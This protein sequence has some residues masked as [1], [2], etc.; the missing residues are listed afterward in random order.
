MPTKWSYE[1]LMVRQFKDNAYEKYFYDLEKE[2]SNSNFKIIYY[3]PELIKRLDAMTV[4]LNSKGKL[5]KTKGNLLLLKNEITI[6][7]KLVP[8]VEFQNM[9]LLDLSKFNLEATITIRDYLTALLDHYQKNYD[10]A[11]KRKHNKLNY[12]SINKPLVYRKFNDYYYN[13]HL[14]DMVQKVFEKDKN[15]LLE[16]D[17]RLIQQIDP[18]YLDPYPNGYFDFRAHFY[19]PV[20]H[21]KGSFYDTYWFNMI[22]IWCFTLF[23]YLTL[24]FDA[25]KKLL[26]LPEK[27]RM[28]KK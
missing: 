12:L 19:A 7:K 1:A 21:F 23:L 4:E 24:Y 27:I 9:N 14:A 11:D 15:K 22:I 16:Y 5:D 18:I 17:H 3:I 10:E 2:I 13:E 28:K 26:N 6:Q 25:L 20:K 8:E